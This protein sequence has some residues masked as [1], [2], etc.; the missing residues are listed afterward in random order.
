MTTPDQSRS[1][2]NTLS[3]FKKASSK[4]SS[5]ALDESTETIAALE[6]DMSEVQIEIADDDDEKQSLSKRT[7]P[8]EKVPVWMQ[9]NAFITDAYR[10]PL[11]S[12]TACVKSLFY[13]HNESAPLRPVLGAGD[14]AV[15]YVFILGAMVCLA[16]SSSFHCFLSHSEKVS[17]KGATLLFGKSVGPKKE[18]GREVG[19]CGDFWGHVAYVVWQKR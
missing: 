18:G 8:F 7:V 5:V 10:P 17:K 4:R 12:Y 19:W 13:Q 14:I 9:D 15:F 6:N 16:M 11:F 2:V 3:S 1:E